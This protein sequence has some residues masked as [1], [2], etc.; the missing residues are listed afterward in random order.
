MKTWK[1]ETQLYDEKIVNAL[2]LSLE[3]HKLVFK[4]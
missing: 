3:K 1:A 2:V 4:N